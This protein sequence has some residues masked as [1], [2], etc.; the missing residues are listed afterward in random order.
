MGQKL[1]AEYNEEESLVIFFPKTISFS[2]C[3]FNC[4]VCNI[5]FGCKTVVAGGH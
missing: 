5:F 1:S 3:F 4:K 2:C